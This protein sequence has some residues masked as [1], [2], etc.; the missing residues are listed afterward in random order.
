MLFIPSYAIS[1]LYNRPIF[2]RTPERLNANPL[3]EDM[4]PNIL[5]A[6]NLREGITT[7]RKFASGIGIAVRLIVLKQAG[8]NLRN[9]SSVPS[10]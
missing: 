9:Q 5:G 1:N 7:W 4:R 3:S 8:L 2:R 10:R 6:L